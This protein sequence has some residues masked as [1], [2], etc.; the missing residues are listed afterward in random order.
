MDK[1][2]RHFRTCSSIIKGECIYFEFSLSISE[3]LMEMAELIL[4]QREYCPRLEFKYIKYEEDDRW[5][6]LADMEKLDKLNL[7]LEAF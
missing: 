3:L 7:E 6:R 5:A 4:L 2:K 1:S